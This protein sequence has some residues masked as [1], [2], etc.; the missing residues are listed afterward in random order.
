[1][2]GSLGSHQLI[3][4]RVDYMRWVEI[5]DEDQLG[6][7]ATIRMVLVLHPPTND[8]IVCI[9]STFTICYHRELES[10]GMMDALEEDYLRVT[11]VSVT[12]IQVMRRTVHPKERVITIHSEAGDHGDPSQGE[13]EGY[14]GG[15]PWSSTDRQYPAIWQVTPTSSSGGHQP[16]PSPHITR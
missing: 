9:A 10:Y 16:S 7:A 13:L 14:D 4:P 5:V 8:P 6:E 11:Q 12:A 1:M 3:I 2:G 15:S